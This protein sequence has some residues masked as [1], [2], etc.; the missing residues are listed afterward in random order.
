MVVRLL[1]TEDNDLLCAALDILGRR[2]WSGPIVDLVRGW[3]AASE[4]TSADQQA[5]RGAL[6]AM[7]D[8][9]EIQRLIADALEDEETIGPTR[10][11]LLDVIARCSL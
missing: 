4:L 11:L 5:L 8:N 7:D 9:G 10:Q 1:D 3:L 2:G 6:L